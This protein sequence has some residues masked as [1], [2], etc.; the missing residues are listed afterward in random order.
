MTTP[1]AS[2]P[3]ST[4]WLQ[5]GNSILSDA[6]NIWGQ[7]Q[8]AKAQRSTS[9]G[10]Q[11]AR[12]VQ[13]DLP[14]GQAVQIDSAPKSQSVDEMKIL[15]MKPKDLLV[16]SVLVLGSAVALKYAGFK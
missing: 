13:P 12:L 10:D 4:N 1:L 11:A 8:V 9:G 5:Q 3:A 14:S 16:L 15:G 2:A 7:V 6:L